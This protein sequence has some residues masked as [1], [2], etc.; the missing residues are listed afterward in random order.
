INHSHA[1]QVFGVLPD[2]SLLI[3]GGR[4]KDEIGFSLVSTGGSVGELKVTDFDKMMR[5]KF[6]GA[7]MSADKKHMIIYFSEAP[8]S[9]RSDLYIS[10]LTDNGTYTKPVKLKI[11]D[12]SDEFGPFLSPNDK[13]LYYASDRSDPNKQGGSDIYRSE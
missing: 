5:G 11:T 7:T 9:P 8:Q 6:Y 3:R 12:G 2:G 10:H 1:N 13:T 4:G